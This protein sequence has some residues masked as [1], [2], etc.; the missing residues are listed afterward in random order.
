MDAAPEG[1]RIDPRA[2]LAAIVE[3]L[4]EAIIGKTLEG[5]VT[6]WNLGAERLY[7]YTADEV[8]GRSIVMIA[9]PGRQSEVTEIMARLE[10]GERVPPFETV[11]RHKDGRLIPIR[12]SVSPIKDPSGRTIGSASISRD[13]TAQKQAE[14]ALRASQQQAIEIL[15]SISDGFYTLDREERLTYVNRRTEE[16]WGRRREE[17]LGRPFRD[18]FPE[19]TGTHTYQEH[20]RAAREGRPIEYQT[21][22][23]IVGRWIEVN[24]YPSPTG[25]TVYFR[26]ITG[27]KQA[28]EAAQAAVRV[29]DEVL[30]AVSHDLRNPLTAIKGQAQLMKRWAMRRDL[31]NETEVLLRGVQQIDA[32]A[33]R[34]S[35]WIDE[36]LDVTRLQLGEELPLRL[37][38]TDLVGLVRQAVH[39]N[40]QTTHGHALRL[41]LPESPL[42][43]EYDAARLRRVVENLLSNAIKYSPAG[44]E[45][46]VSLEQHQDGDGVWAVLRVRDR[47]MGIPECDQPHIFERFHRAGNVAGRI[48]GT[49]LGLAGSC[50]IVQQHGG[51]ISVDSRE[52][53]GS[54]FTVRLP[55]PGSTRRL[56]RV[57]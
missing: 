19:V 31:S 12:L 53:Q 51:S 39:D 15:E 47:G 55:L 57:A 25:M 13:L 7:G 49:G 34:M 24:I 48:A 43:G 32:A 27:R 2:E 42:V 4:D 10:G 33:T 37:A 1:P 52:Q 40:Q 41:E 38:A 9:P 3:S 28:E 17:V 23:P 45:I 26:D 22:S 16:L 11:R 46:T 54:T 36:L 14:S 35:T 18:V 20:Q 8:I 44:G 29:R 5:T 21:F 50:R 6:S 30:S 56:G